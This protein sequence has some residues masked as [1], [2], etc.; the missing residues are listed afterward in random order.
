MKVVVVE[1]NPVDTRLLC[2]IVESAGHE[3]ITC[4]S[5]VDALDEIILRRPDVVLVDLDLPGMGGLDLVRALR[6]YT[7]IVPVLAM[8]AYPH[9]YTRRDA[10]KVG[11]SDWLVKPLDTRGLLPKLLSLSRGHSP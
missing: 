2:A 11:C 9:S 1:D 3:I 5:A 8:T 10:L 4:G 7:S 6:A